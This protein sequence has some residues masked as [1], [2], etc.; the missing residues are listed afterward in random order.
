MAWQWGAGSLLARM[1]FLGLV[2]SSPGGPFIHPAT[3]GAAAGSWLYC[4]LAV[5]PVNPSG[6]G[7]VDLA[8][9]VLQRAP[10][11]TRAITIHP[12][13]ITHYIHHSCSRGRR[14]G[15]GAP[16]YDNK[17]VTQLIAC[18]YRLYR[19]RPSASRHC[20]ILYRSRCVAPSPGSAPRTG[21]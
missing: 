3:E 7:C 8:A 20:R 6:P 5:E 15:N 14:S 13:T 1:A 17:D 11:Q 2:A 12:I 10:Q 16:T 4:W 21:A 9:E 18:I 19:Q